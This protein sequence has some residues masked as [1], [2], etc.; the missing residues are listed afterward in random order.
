[1]DAS[2]ECWVF[3]YGSLM[4]RPGFDF[5]ECHKARLTGLHRALC[6]Y[7]HVHR[8]TP[9][10]PGL[11]LGLDRGGA[12]TGLAFR[13]APRNW[14]AVCD[15]LRAREQVTAVY[16]EALR[17]ITLDDGRDVQALTYIVDRGHPQYAGKL[18]LTQQLHF[19]RQGHGQSGANTD[20]VTATAGELTRLGLRDPA[21]H[22][23]AARIRAHP[24]PSTAHSP[25]QPGHP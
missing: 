25:P 12:C 9:E 24:H 1:M 10:R 22:W 23:L 17:R 14:T 5:V 11:V 18:S 7:S 4:W 19:V 3:G 6:I 15:Y 20:Y 21:L 16:R 13:V 2:N 8:G